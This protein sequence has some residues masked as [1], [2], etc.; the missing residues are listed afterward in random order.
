MEK[1]Y[2]FRIY[3]NKT[4][5][6]LLQKTFG[7]VRFIYNYFLDKRIKVYE[8]NKKTISY[9]ECSKELTQLKKEK[10]WL[11]EPD[12]SSLQNALKNLDTAYK[13]FFNRQKVGFP[14]FKS[15][16]N[17]YKSYKT[18]MTNNNIVF[19]GNKIKL[20][21]IGKIKTR[22]KYRQIEGRILSATVSQ[23]PSG[24]YYVALC[25]TDLPQ[26]EFIKTNKSVGLDL[27]I[28]DFVITSDAVKYSNPKYLQKSLTRLAKLQRELS[29]KTK[30]SSNWE[31]ARVK[32]AK[33]HDRIANQRHNLLH[34]VTCQL[35]RNYD[36]ICLEDLQVENMMKN[37][38]LARNIAD[39]S[40]S[41]FIRQLKYK[42]EWFG[43][44]IVKID[45]FY[46]SSQLCHVC[47]YKNTEVKDLNVREWNCPKCKTHHDRDVNAAINIR[48]EGLRI[49]NIA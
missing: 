17:R 41:E 29:R 26:P 45:K 12:K 42:A 20:P 14:K 28:K 31:K 23:T 43:R 18:N 38:K 6:C 27:G 8:Q 1:A 5:E 3:P 49:L 13:N 25:C 2:K 33:L 7:C 46:P 11:K 34:Q 24:K 48:N 35:I 40:W 39:V 15:K 30:G 16:K 37:H 10:K 32:V 36:V 22:D 21:K 47:G 4:Q 19:L 9:N 44:V